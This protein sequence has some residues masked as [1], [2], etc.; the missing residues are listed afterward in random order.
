M[1]NAS[2]SVTD[3][4]QSEFS[5]FLNHSNSIYSALVKLENMVRLD[6]VS[7]EDGTHMLTVGM[8]TKVYIYAQVFQFI[9]KLHIFS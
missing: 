3:I 2:S 6:W 7:T 1:E 9:L 5:F 4:A 8:G